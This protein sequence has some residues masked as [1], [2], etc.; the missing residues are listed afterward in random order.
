MIYQVQ[1]VLPNYAYTVYDGSD[2]K[3]MEKVIR[4]W[5]KS[6]PKATFII[7]HLEIRGK[8]FYDITA[9]IQMSAQQ[10]LG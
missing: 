6:T 8:N 2:K 1:M 10:V 3:K 7:N 9:T 5:A 4:K